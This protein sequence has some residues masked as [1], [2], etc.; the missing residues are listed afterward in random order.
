[1]TLVKKLVSFFVEWV[2]KK[3]DFILQI[4]LNEYKKKE[5]TN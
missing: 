3:L 1:M 5:K 2:E 4:I